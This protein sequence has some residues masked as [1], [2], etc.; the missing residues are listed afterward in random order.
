MA[1]GLA[2][3]TLSMSYKFF[4]TKEELSTCRSFCWRRPSVLQLIR[5]PRGLYLLPMPFTTAVVSLRHVSATSATLLAGLA[6]TD[7][8][9]EREGIK[10][11]AVF[12]VRHKFFSTNYEL[13]AC[14][15]FFRQ[16]ASIPIHSYASRGF[17]SVA[18]AIHNCHHHATTSPCYNAAS[19]SGIGGRGCCCR[20]DS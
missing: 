12:I 20:C 8:V 5:A 14:R 3:T 10:L 19:A 16:R 6:V 15:S 2:V 4:S 18:S 13:S 11:W 7:V 1:G 9:A 17:F